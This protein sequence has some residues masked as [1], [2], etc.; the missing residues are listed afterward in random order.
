M[1]S[2]SEYNFPDFMCIGAQKSATSWLYGCL[3]KHPEVYMARPKEIH[4]FDLPINYRNGLGW[5]SNHFLF[6]GKKKKGEITPAYS[7]LGDDE[8]RFI[9]KIMPNLKLIYLLRNPIE[10]AWSQAKMELMLIPSKKFEEVPQQ[11]FY[12]HFDNIGSLLRGDYAQCL[13]NWYVH[14]NKESILVDFYEN[15]SLDPKFLISRIVRVYRNITLY[16]YIRSF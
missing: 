15:V 9:K 12:N 1:K 10:R 7:I 2:Y 5:Y 16:Y 11:E 8:I 14:F 4:F 13:K 6:S 3:G